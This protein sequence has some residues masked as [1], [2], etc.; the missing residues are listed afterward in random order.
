MGELNLLNYL[1]K[2]SNACYSIS[3]LSNWVISGMYC[4]SKLMTLGAMIDVGGKLGNL[5]KIIRL[6]KCL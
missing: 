5:T 3:E 2:R 1:L 6:E 4:R